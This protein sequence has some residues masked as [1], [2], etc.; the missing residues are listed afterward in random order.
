MSEPSEGMVY[1]ASNMPAGSGQAPFR[2]SRVA[3]LFTCGDVSI[4]SFLGQEGACV[5]KFGPVSVRM[6]ADGQEL[7]IVCFRFFLIARKLGRARGAGQRVETIWR[8]AQ[9]G[10]E[11][12]HRLRGLLQFQQHLAKQFASWQDDSWGDVVLVGPVL[13]LSGKTHLGESVFGIALGQRDPCGGGLALDI[14]LVSPIAVVDL[15]KRVTQGCELVYL[16]FGNID[17]PHM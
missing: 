2:S 17:L 11:L 15:R 6:R 9:R 12:D 13:M 16:F 4:C 7:G 10:F 5:L 14:H 1:S 3:S 8:R